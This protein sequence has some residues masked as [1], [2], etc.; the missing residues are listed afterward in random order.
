MACPLAVVLANSELDKRPDVMNHYFMRDLKTL[1]VTEK[2]QAQLPASWRKQ[3][4]LIHGGAC[5]LRFLDDGRHSLLIT[6]RV[7]KRRGAAG[8]LAHLKSQEVAFPKVER[9]TMPFK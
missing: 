5:D 9:H 1:T 4:G 6:P 2:G 3:A 8:L 7:Q